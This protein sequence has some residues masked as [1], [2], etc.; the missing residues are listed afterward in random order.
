M[1]QAARLQRPQP[2]PRPTRP[3]YYSVIGGR[4]HWQP[5]KR[6]RALG[7]RN[8]ACGDDSPEARAIAE[9]MNRQATAARLTGDAARAV[10]DAPA[11]TFAV[12]DMLNAWTWVNE[13]QL[14]R[15]RFEEFELRTAPRRPSVCFQTRP[16]LASLV[17]RLRAALHTMFHATR[18]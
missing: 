16:P 18:R 13:Q 17:G 15:R 6:L 7:F 14:R 8:V 12:Y 2:Q 11:Q 10:T 4:G 9:A 1:A 5:G 3:L